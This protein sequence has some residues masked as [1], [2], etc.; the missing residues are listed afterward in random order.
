[1]ELLLSLL[2]LAVVIAFGFAL[3]GVPVLF[4]R[5]HALTHQVELLRQQLGAVGLSSVRPHQSSSFAAEG[6]RVDADRMA[7]PNDTRPDPDTRQDSEDT[8]STAVDEPS[9]PSPWASSAKSQQAR[10]TADQST[11]PGLI[12]RLLQRLMTINLTAQVGGVVLIFGAVFLGKY[13]SDIGLLTLQ[14]KLILMAVVSAAM[15]V[16]GVF[17]QSRLRVYG[18]IL[19]GT[20]LAGW[21]VTLFVAHLLYQ[22][23][24]WT[25]AFVAGITAVGLIGYRALRQASQGLAMVAFLGGFITP[26]IAGSDVSSLWRLFAYL[27]LLNVAVVWICWHRPWRWLVRE[28]YVGTYGVIAALMLA[29]YLQDDLYLSVIQWPFAAFIILSLVLFSVLSGSWL[30]H[31]IPSLEKHAPGLLFGVPATAAVALQA[32]LR[33]EPLVLAGVLIALAIW[34]GVLAN[35]ARRR[36]FWVLTVLFAS[37]AVPYAL[38]D[39]VTSLVYSL[40]GLAFVYWACRQPRLTTMIWGLGLQLL[41][42]VFAFRLFQDPL[43]RAEQLWVSW[44]LYGG[45]V[46]AAL[47]TAW[48]HEQSRVLPTRLSAFTRVGLPGWA[49]LVWFYQWGFWFAEL[50]SRQATLAGFSFVSAVTVGLAALLAWRLNW[51]SLWLAV[52]WSCLIF[53]A[54]AALY[55]LEYRHSAEPLNLVILA[56]LSAALLIGR[57]RLSQ[58]LLPARVWDGLPVWFGLCGIMVFGLYSAP[59]PESDWNL[60]L[61][62]LAVFVPGLFLQRSLRRL[63]PPT[64][65]RT[66]ARR[67]SLVLMAGVLLGSFTALGNYPPLPFWPLLHPLLLLGV[68]GC[69]I[70][71]RF[72]RLNR[73]LRLAWIIVCGM[74][75]TME[76]NRWLFHYTGVAYNPDAWLA[77]A[78]T[79]TV[80]SLA[81]TILGGLLM[82]TGT[83]QRQSQSRSRW[84]LGA[85]ILALIVVKLFVLDLAQVDTLYRILSFIG[86]GGLLLGIGYFAPMPQSAR[87]TR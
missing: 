48:W 25:T 70:L 66:F 63:L 30:Y 43:V 9:T 50:F 84:T 15:I 46:A 56:V 36:I 69:W 58:T 73:P 78:L 81:W 7:A 40:E 6:E 38:N 18:D 1:M 8:A 14:A 42:A 83:W 29:E 65:L 80:W 41:A 54:S 67:L 16:V 17:Y 49:L 57:Y 44:L 11:G 85:A 72:V 55:L 77:S 86:V 35:F 45:V 21:L 39:A 59:K 37:G 60:S 68:F 12:Q 75:L 32:L 33:N 52:R 10:S 31:R 22:Q 61:A 23:M 24:H 51:G 47:L 71:F 5:I 2:G 64:V 3:I 28:A 82:V 53:I 76:L 4:R 87:Q 26:F 19:Q 34:Y 74:L 13:A 62:M 20:G 79:Q 27:S